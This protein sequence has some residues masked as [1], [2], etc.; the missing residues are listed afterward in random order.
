M[1]L[2]WDFGGVLFHWLPARLVQ[3]ELPQRATDDTSAAHWV[4]EIFQNYGGDWSEFDRGTVSEPELVRRIAARTGLAAHEVQAVVDGVP[5][6][7]Q[8]IAETVALL[9][10]L[11][12]AGHTQ[13]Y[14]SNMP[15]PYADHLEAEHDFVRWFDAGVFSA[16]VQ[17]IK[18]EP[19]IFALAAEQFGVPPAELLFF[20]DH[21]PNVEA[22]RQAGWNAHRFTN[23]AEAES[24]LLERGLL[25]KAG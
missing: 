9:G 23:A 1:K 8:P 14:L 6:E 10:R 2:V 4:R 25:P 16:R 24:A 11:R 18:P 19:A 5:G 21:V 13:F 17:H 3:R 15:A 7:L 22:A 20:D 12:D